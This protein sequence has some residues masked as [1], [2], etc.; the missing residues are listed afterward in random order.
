LPTQEEPSGSSVGV[1]SLPGDILEAGVATLPEERENG[2]PY[3]T[4]RTGFESELLLAY[5]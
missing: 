2:K 1:G 3:G 4:G 5:W